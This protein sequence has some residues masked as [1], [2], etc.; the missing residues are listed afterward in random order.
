MMIEQYIDICRPPATSVQ[1]RV[2]GVPEVVP[3]SVIKDVCLAPEANIDEML[4][5][6]IDKQDQNIDNSAATTEEGS[7]MPMMMEV[8][9]PVVRRKKTWGPVMATRTSSRIPKDGKSTVEKAQIRKMTLN[10]EIPV[11]KKATQGIK[12]SFAVLDDAVLMQ[13]AS[14]AGRSEERRV[15]KECLL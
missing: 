5:E 3:T 12:N 6:D 1:G 15:G 10:L 13:N 11:P 2:C 9:Q 14:K 7:L 4:L 8:H